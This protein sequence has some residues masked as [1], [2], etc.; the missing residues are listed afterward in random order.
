MVTA[1]AMPLTLSIVHGMGNGFIAYAPVK[2]LS[3]KGKDCPPA[4]YV[5]ALLFV[6]K[7]ALL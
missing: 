6:L 3:N 2:V 4:V 1:I 5:I 7:F